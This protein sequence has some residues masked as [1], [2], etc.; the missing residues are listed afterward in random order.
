[1]NQMNLSIDDQY[2]L[3]EWAQLFVLATVAIE[4]G[5]NT[6]VENWVIQHSDDHGLPQPTGDDVEL[7]IEEAV[8]F[9]K[10][11]SENHIDNMYNR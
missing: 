2:T 3:N 10:K 5:D 7:L 8:L 11:F 9:L 6:P 1:M 4:S